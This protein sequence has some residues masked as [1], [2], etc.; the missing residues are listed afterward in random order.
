MPEGEIAEPPRG[1]V[2]WLLLWS[3][4]SENGWQSMRAPLFFAGC[5]AD[6]VKSSTLPRRMKM[7]DQTLYFFF[8]ASSLFVYTTP[9][10]TCQRFPSDTM[11]KWLRFMAR[12]RFRVPKTGC[13]IWS[14]TRVH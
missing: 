6:P 11:Q 14:A 7:R 4:P 9:Q 10:S 3:L 12:T 13:S 2:R 8:L 5:R 1:V